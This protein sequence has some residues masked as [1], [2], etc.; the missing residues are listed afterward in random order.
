MADLLR[1][2]VGASGQVHAITPEAAG[3]THVGFD[4]WLLDPGEVAE[5]RLDGA[6]RSSCWSRAWQR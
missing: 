4:L 1:K 3:W 5:G 6:R 2:P